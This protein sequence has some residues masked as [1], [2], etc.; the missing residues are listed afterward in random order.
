MSVYVNRDSM[1][2]W[3]FITLGKPR[4]ILITQCEENKK[5]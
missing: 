3:W 4:Y 5:K 1:Q 2:K